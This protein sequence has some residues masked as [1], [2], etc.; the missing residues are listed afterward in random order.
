MSLQPGPNASAN[1]SSPPATIPAPIPASIPEPGDPSASSPTYYSEAYWNAFADQDIQG[2]HR[3]ARNTPESQFAE[4]MGLL[5]KGDRHAAETAFMETRQQKS[6]LIVAIASQVML[7]TTLRAERKWKELRDLSATSPLTAQDKRLTSD[8]ERWGRAFADVA[9]E[10]MRFPEEP[11]VLRLRMTA[12]ATPAV[13]LKINGKDFEFWIDTGSSMT[14]LSSAV[15]AEAG[16]SAL[17]S[18]T[19][20]VKTF[21]GTAPVKAA[22]VKRIDLGSIV[23]TNSPAVIIDESL[24]YLRAPG[25]GSKSGLKVD[26]LIGWDIIRQ[27]DLTMD[28]AAGKAILARP[29]PRFTDEPGNLLWLGKPFVELGTKSGGKVHFTLDTGAQSSFIDEAAL[30][31]TGGVTQNADNRVFGIARTT[32]ETKKVASVSLLAGDRLLGLQNII[33]YGPVSPGF[34]NCDGILGSDVAR[35]GVIHIDATNGLF[36]VGESDVDA[37]ENSPE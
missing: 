28:Y 5:A 23:I 27:L 7:A 21:A 10:V 26:G 8:L 15:A 13:H 4:A 25:D 35:F 24:L 20:F 31:K 9:P 34:I 11:T 16:I 33:V 2:L 29:Q 14:V 6:D 22:V 19:L 30:D 36:S 3:I 17:V 32:R 1:R 37:S 18:D 12:V